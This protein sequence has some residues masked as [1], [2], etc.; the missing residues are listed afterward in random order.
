MRRVAG[1]EKLRIQKS[2]TFTGVIKAEFKRQTKVLLKV[3]PVWEDLDHLDGDIKERL[4][5][6]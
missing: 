4:G 3:K 6:G 5:C 2:M 1:A